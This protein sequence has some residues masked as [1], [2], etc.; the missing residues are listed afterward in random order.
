MSRTSEAVPPGQEINQYWL[1]LLRIFAFASLLL[2]VLALALSGVRGTLD[3][4]PIQGYATWYAICFLLLLVKF[5]GKALKTALALALA[6]G[7]LGV[8]VTFLAWPKENSDIAARIDLGLF[9]ITQT[10]VVVSA[11]KTVREKHLSVFFFAFVLFIGFYWG[12]ANLSD[13]QKSRI[14]VNESSAVQSLRAVA[15]ANGTYSSRYHAGFAGSLA[16]LGP[17]SSTC[18]AVGSACAD[19]IDSILSGVAPRS[20]APAES[21]YAFTYAAPNASPSQERPNASF[22][23]VAIPVSPGT[24]GSSTFCI[25]QSNVV[26]RDT[27]GSSKTVASPAA[28]CSGFAGS[29]MQRVP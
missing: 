15:T 17:T 29:P 7:V 9:A 12:L 21:G 8:I 23:L 10:A 19:L 11:T 24:S 6:L 3:E 18:P 26:L 25:D 22:S 1:R 14:A 4:L 13:L 28:G 27:T 16:Q 5:R 20:A 2:V